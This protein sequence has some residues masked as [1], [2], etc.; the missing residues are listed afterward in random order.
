MQVQI[1]LSTYNGERWL[2]ELL[3]SLLWQTHKH[4]QLIIRDDGSTDN[5]WAL[6]QAW[7]AQYPQRVKCVISEREHVGT[8]ESFNRL[9]AASDADYLLF[10]DQD[11][12]W[13]PEK[14]ELQLNALLALET[15]QGKANATL[16]H[17]DLMVVDATKQLLAA[18]FWKAR[19]FNTQQSK[20]HYLIN[21]VVTGCATIFNRAAA[22][23]AFPVPTHA[24]QH[25]RWLALVCVWFGTV[26]A[27]PYQLLFYRQHSTNQIGA[28]R[29]FN[30][31]IAA[32]V[33][34]WSTQAQAFTQR[35]ATRLDP[36]Q[37][38][39][40]VLHALSRLT[41]LKAWQRRQSIVRH[42][43]YKPSFLENVA[44]LLLA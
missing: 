26:Q 7:Q 33:K 19:G 22:N 38:D 13:F 37:A 5:T 15:E 25:D 31:N 32:R 18:S 1:L 20:Q 6:L 34:A 28:R 41:E 30:F 44:L 24:L 14:V 36:Q 21:N 10:C 40:Q 29:P 39:V 27:L 17:A 9:V 43:L 23:L 35:Y 11:D 3:A 16:V 4:W 2:S 42:R 12:V 8:T